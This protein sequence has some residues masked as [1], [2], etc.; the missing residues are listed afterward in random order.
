M[1]QVIHITNK[2]HSPIVGMG[3]YLL[4]Y[5]LFLRKD[6]E[7]D[8]LVDRFFSEKLLTAKINETMAAGAH[9]M[10]IH[11]CG[12]IGREFET[13]PFHKAVEENLSELKH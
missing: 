6:D 9:R 3:K 7:P 2:D 5:S 12:E 10:E 8:L 13:R 1:G 4:V 11:F